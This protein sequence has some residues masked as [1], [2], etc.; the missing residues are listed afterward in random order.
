MCKAASSEAPCGACEARKQALQGA[1][2]PATPAE[3]CCNLDGDVNLLLSLE[4]LEE[5]TAKSLKAAGNRVR[6]LVPCPKADCEGLT[7]ADEGA[8]WSTS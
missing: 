6:D 7:V 8:P 5:Y 3:W 4:E 1:D 2:P